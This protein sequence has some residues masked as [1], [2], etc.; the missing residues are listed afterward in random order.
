MSQGKAGFEVGRY[1]HGGS[2]KSIFGVSPDPPHHDPYHPH[3]V[4]ADPGLRVRLRESDASLVGI[5][6]KTSGDN[7]VDDDDDHDTESVE[8]DG[9]AVEGRPV[10]AG[11]GDRAVRGYRTPVAQK[12]DGN[13]IHPAPSIRRHRKQ[14][15]RP[16]TSI[17][18]PRENS[19]T[20]TTTSS[21]S[22]TSSLW[23]SLSSTTSVDP[24]G[25]VHLGAYMDW[26]SRHQ[27]QWL[28]RRDRPRGFPV[29]LSSATLT[30]NL[31]LRSRGRA[32]GTP[33]S[34]AV[35]GL[36][37]TR[38]D[39]HALGKWVQEQIDDFN[40]KRGDFRPTQIEDVATM[41]RRSFCGPLLPLTLVGSSF[42]RRRTFLFYAR[43]SPI[44]YLSL[45]ST[46]P[47]STP[48]PTLYISLSLSRY[49]AL[50]RRTSR[51]RSTRR[52]PRSCVARSRS[53]AAR[54]AAS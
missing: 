21:S 27:E 54:A 32:A 41:V 18:R 22:S 36:P 6:S 30:K 52:R 7:Q 10:P 5:L 35:Q 20:T 37:G 1:E 12:R 25:P 50:T 23:S 13:E 39:V 15:N 16:K 24:L 28:K 31:R 26:W 2:H 46:L 43:A 14:V 11:G 17:G 44:C 33:G 40:Q 29:S 8:T 53:S 42:V 47:S 34:K 48:R 4:H 49:V 45:V 51:S 19:T 38:A 3:R 9:P